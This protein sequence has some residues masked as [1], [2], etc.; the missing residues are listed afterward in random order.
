MLR[1]LAGVE[2]ALQ[3][4]IYTGIECIYCEMAKQL[5]KDEGIEFKQMNLITKEQQQDFKAL[6]FT[7]VP[8][9]YDDEGNHIGGYNE[10]AKKFKKT[11][12]SL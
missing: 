4:K 6:G 3:Y 1:H 2:R 9:V 5:L 8:Q 7:T 12:Y 11:V 10:L